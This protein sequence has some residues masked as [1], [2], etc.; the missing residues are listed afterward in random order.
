M[1]ELFT[2]LGFAEGP[3]L[4]SKSRFRPSPGWKLPTPAELNGPLRP[5]PL[6]R[7]FHP[8]RHITAS[9]GINRRGL[10]LSP[11]FHETLSSGVG[12]P[13]DIEVPRFRRDMPAPGQHRSAECGDHD[14]PTRFQLSDRTSGLLSRAE[15]R[16]SGHPIKDYSDEPPSN[17]TSRR[18]R[19]QRV[20]SCEALFQ[21]LPSEPDVRLS[22]HPALQ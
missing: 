7:D 22:P 15:R 11:R 19:S 6:G 18:V 16:R 14:L 5:E 3:R 8:L 1:V 4:R 2:A 17:R 9:C 13:A 10:S 20:T 21:P 12:N